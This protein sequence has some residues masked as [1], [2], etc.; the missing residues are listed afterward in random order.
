MEQLLLFV[1]FP[2]IQSQRLVEDVEGKPLIAGLKLTSELL[3]EAYRYNFYSQLYNQVRALCV[4]CASC[5]C[6]CRAVC[7]V[8]APN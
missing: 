3:F 6:V 7:V 2:F 5:A 1:R 8:R 4:F